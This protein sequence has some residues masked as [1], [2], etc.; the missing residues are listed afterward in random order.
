VSPGSPESIAERLRALRVA[1]GRSL[2][3][4]ARELGV[5]FTTVSSWERGR[6]RPNY[7]TLARLAG[8]FDV[9]P[10]YLLEEFVPAA[11]RGRLS[12]GPDAPRF[13]RIAERER[14]A[15]VGELEEIRFLMIASR[16][17]EERGTRLPQLEASTGIPVP[18]LEA[19]LGGDARPTVSEVLH[20]AE[21]LG[22]RIEERADEATVD[23]AWEPANEERLLEVVR[24]CPPS[25][26]PRL[27]RLLMQAARLA[28]ADGVR[29]RGGFH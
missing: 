29:P 2:S 15:L 4:L 27:I 3:D 14:D 7:P 1:S 9:S 26:R 25:V 18:R 11:S 22:I 21:A 6:S 24:G 8:L 23:P 10:D 19:L 16:V 5:H 20:L 17:L 13:Q 28:L 12:A